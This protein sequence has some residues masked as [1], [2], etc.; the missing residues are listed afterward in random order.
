MNVIV[1]SIIIRFG[2]RLSDIPIKFFSNNG[3]CY[4]AKEIQTFGNLLNLEMK[5]MVVSSKEFIKQ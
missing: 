3:S 4:T 2:S 5:T 1:N